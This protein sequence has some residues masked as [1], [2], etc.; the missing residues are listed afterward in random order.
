MKN[1]FLGRRNL[2]VIGVLLLTSS[3]SLAQ[4]NIAVNP[5]SSHVGDERSPLNI[6]IQNISS[7]PLNVEIKHFCDVDGVNYSGDDCLRYFELSVGSKD[8]SPVQKLA[9]HSRA[10]VAIRLK[11]QV[12]RYALYKPVIKQ[13]KEK[14]P[15][16]KG[17][18][19]E[20]DYQPGALFLIAPE[21]RKYDLPKFDLK[22]DGGRK[23][24]RF[25]WD[26]ESWK[27]PQVLSVSAKIIDKNTRKIIKF[28][29][30][31]DGRIVDPSRKRVVLQSEI[32]SGDQAPSACYEVFITPHYGEKIVQ[33]ISNCML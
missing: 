17:V 21:A 24:V 6:T 25:E 10:D 5:L 16:R 26:L 18:G 15:L 11:S 8:F 2:V 7:S 12:T 13:M 20:F 4:E 29:R 27:T 3:K 30:L 28:V 1:A 9:S 22:L 19:F 14:S 33:N 31:A 23:I 32:T